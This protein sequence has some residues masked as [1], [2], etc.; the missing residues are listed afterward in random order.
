MPQPTTIR[1]VGDMN[2]IVSSLKFSNNIL[3]SWKNRHPFQSFRLKPYLGTVFAQFKEY[4]RRKMASFKLPLSYALL[5]V[6]ILFL[7]GQGKELNC[8]PCIDRP[9]YTIQ[10][11]VHG[12]S[13]D[14]FWRRMR[15]TSIQAAKDM[16]VDLKFDLYGKS[17]ELAVSVNVGAPSHVKFSYDDCIAFLY[18]QRRI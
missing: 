5:I 6:A 3:F 4:C 17:M 16:R 1:S 7:T 2:T 18:F 15:A 9:T 12:T 10:A 13:D 14:K 11:I 8:D